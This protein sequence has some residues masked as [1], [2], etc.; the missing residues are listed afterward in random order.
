MYDAWAKLD[1]L[2]ECVFC[3]GWYDKEFGFGHAGDAAPK[4]CNKCYREVTEGVLIANM[5][6]TITS[7]NSSIPILLRFTDSL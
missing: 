5:R 2:R 4:M 6:A 1:G 3:L 7:G